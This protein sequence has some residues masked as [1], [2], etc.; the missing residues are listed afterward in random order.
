LNTPR[1]STSSDLD[2]SGAPARVGLLFV[3]LGNICRS[4]LAKWI[5]AHQAQKRGVLD[6][7]ELDSCGTGNWHAGGGADPRSTAI[8]QQYGLECSHCAR[9]V[10]PLTDFSRFEYLL[11]MDR[12]NKSNLLKLGAPPERVFLMRSFDQSLS[13]KGEEHLE[14]PD[15]YYGGDDGFEKVYKML[16]RASEGLLDRVTR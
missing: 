4:P 3:C 10:V 6:R 12:Q 9:Q 5:F 15:P 13:G 16:W 1:H 7:F 14:V 11:A 8:A 2:T